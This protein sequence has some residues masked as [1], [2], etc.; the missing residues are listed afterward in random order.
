MS[1]ISLVLGEGPTDDIKDSVGIAGKK[2]FKSINFT[3]ANIRFSLKL[4]YNGDESC[5]YLNKTDFQI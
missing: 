2:S 5:F 3:K 1:K 4:H